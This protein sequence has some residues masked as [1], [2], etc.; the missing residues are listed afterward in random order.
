[1]TWVLLKGITRHGKNRVHQHGER[2]EIVGEGHF[3]GRSA[4]N[5]RSERPTEGPRGAKV[6]D[7][8]WVFKKDDPNFLLTKLENV[9]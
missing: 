7:G 8:R 1:M 3:R 9:V 6:H 4:W 5:L 2:W